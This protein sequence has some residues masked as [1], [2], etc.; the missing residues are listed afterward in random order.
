MK[1]F[2]SPNLYRHFLIILWAVWGTGQICAQ[3]TGSPHGLLLSTFDVDATPPISSPLTYDSTANSWDLGLRAKGIVIQGAGLPIVLVAIDW[4][5]IANESQD[6]FKSALAEAAHTTPERVAVHA[7]HQHDAPISD[8]GAEKMLIEAGLDPAAFESSFDKEVIR[9][10]QAAIQVSLKFAQPVTHIGT[11]EAAVESVASNRRILGPDGKAI[12]SRTSSTKDSTMRA[13]P[14]GLI[15]PMVQLISFWNEE[16]PLSVLSYYAVH[17]QSYYL[18][19]VANP[20]FPG[21]ARFLRQLAVPEALHIHFNGAGANITAGKYNDGSPENRLILAERMAEGMRKAW[22]ATEK[23]PISAV[24]VGWTVEPVAL[25]PR[26]DLHQLEEQMYSEGYR[27]LSNNMIKLAWWKRAEA[28]KTIDISCL[29]LGPVRVLHM[30]GELFVE[31]QLAAKAERPDLFVAMAAYGDYGPFY[32]GD[33]AAYGQGGYEAVTSP[34]TPEAEAVLMKAVRTLLHEGGTTDVPRPKSKA[35]VLEG[36]EAA[37]GDLPDRENLPPMNIEVLDSRRES[38]YTRQSIVFTVAEGEEVPAYL[39]IPD[40]NASLD[41]L[42]AMLVLHGTGDLGKQ[43]VDGKSHLANRA[44]AKELAERGYVVIAPDYPSMGDLKDYNFDTDRYASGTMKAIFNHMRSVDLLTELAEVDPER[45][46]VIGHSLGGHNAIFVGAFDP[47]L[48]VIVSSCGWTPFRHYD[49]GEEA[50]QRYGGRL[51][52]WA[53]DRYMPLIRD[54]FALD[55]TQIPFDF[56]EVIASLAPRAFFT[57]SPKNDSNFDV[58]GVHKGLTIITAAYHKEGALDNL[59]AHFP[60]AGHDFP[61]ETRLAAYEF[62][63]KVLQHHPSKSALENAE[64]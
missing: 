60:A 56:P 54:K 12:F 15:D 28:G 30:P 31:Y 33:S 35:E 23:H 41:K 5:G 34:V 44:L 59:Q 53:Q 32:I 25:K 18:T 55:E 14:E 63:D 16:E 43:L 20:D 27:F 17:P 21:V 1:F 11:G 48:K 24:D 8:F 3:Q 26:P 6:A 29:K 49:I 61:T 37:M 39:Y 58:Q 4:I 22:E 13:K 7:L 2:L 38:N 57:N 64:P 42:P 52:P 51:G 36:M 46:G 10:L 62:I 50:S 40:R 47:R 9:R 19:K 45:I